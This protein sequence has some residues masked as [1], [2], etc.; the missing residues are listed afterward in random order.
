MMI[1]LSL[2]HRF[3]QRLRPHPQSMCQF[4]NVN[5]TDIAFPTL[6]AADIVSMK[7]AK[8]R[9]F[10]LREASLQTQFSHAL[11]D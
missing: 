8:L 10:F 11:S 2:A 4:D 7:M 5:Q 6:N 9:Q 3:Q 1:F